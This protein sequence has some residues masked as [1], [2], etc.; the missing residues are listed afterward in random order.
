MKNEIIIFTD[1]SSLGNPGRGGWG[2]II[3]EPHGKVSEIGGF[4][5]NTTN[6][7]MELRAA[8]EALITLERKKIDAGDIV[9]HTDSAYLLNGITKWVYGWERNNWI[10]K[11]GAT[12]LNQEYWETLL[13]VERR[14]KISRD[15]TWK[16][17]S[18]H[19][20]VV[21]NERCDAIATSFAEEKLVL[22]FSGKQSDYEKMLGGDVLSLKH[23]TEMAAKRSKKAGKGYSYV[24]LV[25]GKVHVDSTWTE[26]EKRVKGKTG[27]KYQKAMNADEEQDLIAQFSL[28]SL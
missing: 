28:L 18:A 13:E 20:G 24:S 25:N 9:I 26:C 15:I 5:K 4:E 16:K 8:I 1:G 3:I 17:V 21:G 12:V 22:L 27:V 19:S 11:E 6:N 23:N 2:A 10:T 7:R 14:L